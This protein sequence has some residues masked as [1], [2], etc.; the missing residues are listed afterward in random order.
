MPAP[1]SRLTLTREIARSAIATVWEGFDSS[2]DRKVLV[3]SIHPQYARES[4]LRA[5]FER[6]AKA[7]AKLSHPNVVQIF[8]LRAEGDELSLILEFVE[9]TT[10]RR[11]LKERGP[12]PAEAA[13]TITDEILAGLEQAHAAGIIHRD[14]KPENVLVSTRGEVKITDF[15]LASLR[16]QPTVTQEGMVVGTPSYMAPE[17]ATGGEILPATDIF[18]VGLMLFEMLTDRRAHEGATMAETFQ[19]VLKYQPPKLEQYGEQIP[20]A[21]R[22]ILAA[23]LEKTAAKRPQHATDVRRTLLESSRDERLPRTLLQDFLSGEPTRKATTP[24]AARVQAWSKP[25]RWFTLFTLLAAGG[26]LIFHFATLTVSRTPTPP[27]TGVSTVE[28][29]MVMPAT[30]A[31]NEIVPYDTT[32]VV[33]SEANAGDSTPEL[34]SRRVTP[35]PVERLPEPVIVERSGYLSIVS[36]PWAQVYLGDSLIGNTPLGAALEL[37]AGEHNVV[38]L[39]PEIGLPVIRK[40]RVEGGDTTLLRVNLYENV[41]RIR[42]ASVK[43]W[44]DVYIDGTN[45]LRTPS[46]RTIFLT[47]GTHTLTLRHPD[48]PEFTDTLTFREG[49]P[50]HEIRVDLT[51]PR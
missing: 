18:A 36:Q 31:E 5:R 42:A 21:V 10:L 15:G 44:A 46:S 16:D 49:D 51:Q 24:T 12:L 7:I 47:L 19:N 32:S 27:E 38:L 35:P 50:V 3:K 1:E 48:F 13:L 4:D 43:P 2:L 20:E 28:S 41:G 39:N 25:F 40:A 23:M 45:V 14:L 37:A 30:G 22:P 8:D 33:P 11:V 29:V 34:V 17:Q 26:G 6:E 9:G